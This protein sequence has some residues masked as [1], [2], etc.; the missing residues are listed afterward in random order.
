MMLSILRKKGLLYFDNNGIDRDL[1]DISDVD[2]AAIL[3]G[4]PELA[5]DDFTLLMY[6]MNSLTRSLMPSQY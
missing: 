6:A 4:K 2:L 3:T 1:G 5:V